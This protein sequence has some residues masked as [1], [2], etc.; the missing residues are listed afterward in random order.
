MRKTAVAGSFYAASASA[1]RQQIEWCFTH[2]L[3]PGELPQ[4][5][6]GPRDIRGLVCPHAGYI[7]SGPVAAHGFSRLASDGKPEVVVIISPNHH[8][9]GASVA[10]SKEDKWQT[11][12][13][14]I[15][16]ATKTGKQIISASRR[17]EWDNSAHQWEHAI[18][19]QLPFLQYLYGSAFQIVPI[20]ML[21][22]DL[23]TSQDLGQAIA[24][25]LKD[26]NGLI[27]ASSDFTH[28][29]PQAT[30]EKKDGLAL[31]AILN[32]EPKR[33]VEVVSSYDITMCGPGPVMSMLIATQIL[34]AK[35]ADLLR[36]A[37]SGNITGN[38]SQ[39]VGYASVVVSLS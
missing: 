27:I 2:T 34:G 32:F 14:E 39:V 36:Y 30:A 17:A 23:S 21:R 16:V 1:L 10:V 38:Y 11:P 3:G 7:Y 37:T 4:V 5:K 25:V 6:E 8:G 29:E 9:I 33:L 24:T 13:G 20:T 15:E 22:Q 35:K 19:V 12:L 28:Y 31:E 26:T 18:E